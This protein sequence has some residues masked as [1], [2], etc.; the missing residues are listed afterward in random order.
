[1]TTLNRPL[2][3]PATSSTSDHYSPRR[4]HPRPQ[5]DLS[6]RLI[7]EAVVASYI[8]DISAR[9]AERRAAGR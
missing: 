4:P 6:S 8:H 9:T 2:T 1:M 5:Q 3:R 7:T